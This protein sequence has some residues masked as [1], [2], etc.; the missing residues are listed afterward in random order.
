MPEN[1]LQGAAP[2]TLFPLKLEIGYDLKRRT[3][4]V[5]WYPDACQ[6][7]AKPHADSDTMLRHYL[8]EGDY[9]PALP[10]TVL[11][12]TVDAVGAVQLLAEA[13]PV[14][15]ELVKFA[16]PN[17]DP[18]FA[19][20]QW[21]WDFEVA[22]QQG[23]GITLS[24]A[25]FDRLA[26]A[27]WL[28]A[29]GY[30]PDDNREVVGILLSHKG[31]D[32]LRVLADGEPTNNTEDER[33]S[34][35]T[36]APSPR[37]TEA[38]RPIAAGVETNS[39][40]LSDALDGTGEVWNGI[41]NSDLTDREIQK[42][43]HI[44][45]WDACT[46]HL[47]D[48]GKLSKERYD[49]LRSAFVD[50]VR[51]RGYLPGL[52]IGR[53]P[54]GLLVAM[55]NERFGDEGLLSMLA[56]PPNGPNNLRSKLLGLALLHGRTI[57]RNARGLDTL[58]A[59]FK[60]AGAT[61][62]LAQFIAERGDI[63]YDPAES[64][65]DRLLATLR[66][67][68]V[69]SRCD[70]L[71]TDG[72]ATQHEQ[73]NV[74]LGPSDYLELP[75]DKAGLDMQKLPLF[76]RLLVLS[77][78]AAEA[79]GRK[80]QFDDSVKL[81]FST[82]KG[83]L[84][85]LTTLM[86]EAL[87]CLSYRVDAWV[88][89]EAVRRLKSLPAVG[90]GRTPGGI[91]VFGWLENPVSASSQVPCEYHQAPSLAQAQTLAV[92]R[93]GSLT[94]E[95]ALHIDLSG[96]RTSQAL[97]LMGEMLAGIPLAEALG[98]EAAAGFHEA[99]ADGLLLKLRFLRPFNA[100]TSAVSCPIDGETFALCNFQEPEK[101]SE[102]FK[103]IVAAVKAAVSESEYAT[104]L[105]IWRD[106][107][108]QRDALADLS[109]AEAV[110]EYN[111]GNPARAKS[112][113]DVAEGKQ[114]PALP[115]VVRSPVRCRNVQQRALL[116]T[117][118][119]TAAG[120][121]E[122]DGLRGVV[123]PSFALLCESYL[124][125]VLEP[126]KPLHCLVRRLSP[127]TVTRASPAVPVD[128]YTRG[129]T[130]PGALDLPVGVMDVVLGGKQEV[131]RR[132]KVRVLQNMAGTAT[133]PALRTLST[134]T[135]A[136]MAKEI[137]IE[138]A[139]ERWERAC[140]LGARLAALLKNAQ[141]LRTIDFSLEYSDLV[142]SADKPEG[143]VIAA[144]REAISQLRS[145]APRA[146][147]AGRYLEAL[148]QR[149]RKVQDA[150]AN[151]GADV[152]AQYLDLADDIVRL[153]LGDVLDLGGLDAAAAAPGGAKARRLGEIGEQ[154]DKRAAALLPFSGTKFS[155][156]LDKSI[157]VELDLEEGRRTRFVVSTAGVQGQDELALG[158]PDAT[159]KLRRSRQETIVDLNRAL[160]DGV[161]A[162]AVSAAVDA[163]AIAAQTVRVELCRALAGSCGTDWDF[164]LPPVDSSSLNKRWLIDGAADPAR[165]L[166][167]LRP[168]LEL[169]GRL[170]QGQPGA[171]KCVVCTDRTKEEVEADIK[172]MLLAAE[173]T[174]QEVKSATIEIV[175]DAPHGN[176][177][178]HLYAASSSSF[179]K[180]G[181]A[182]TITGLKIDEWVDA[183]NVEAQ[184]TAIAFNFDVPQAEAPNAILIT[185][186]S[187]AAWQPGEV[188][189]SLSSVLD[190]LR[191]RTLSID[192]LLTDPQIAA[193]LP[194]PQLPSDSPAFRGLGLMVAKAHGPLLKAE[195]THLVPGV[196]STSVVFV[197]K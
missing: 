105:R 98:Q 176:T 74:N 184:D 146:T 79:A 99:K 190:L 158:E 96:P 20:S 50:D 85:E 128:V 89:A 92:L 143:H 18:T 26:A 163:A 1:L 69:S 63:A 23:M 47:L 40:L 70:V 124:K 162:A 179:E 48:E 120:R 139:D 156:R 7:K 32:R 126:S 17:R 83:R 53:N 101:N 44:C 100:A 51:G 67:D 157:S 171:Y 109:V 197:R 77:E 187:G 188:A 122:L 147:E 137:S 145:L 168:N 64:D 141:E 58:A 8:S 102:D 56:D 175:E 119:V 36:A 131:E 166:E 104:I 57:H 108:D 165:T 14:K 115:E 183:I 11:L 125:T 185:V 148:Q 152:D 130:A 46:R 43:V 172:K 24:G 135:S 61:G 28:L 10:D 6:V 31:Q 42:Q 116:L 195:Q 181:T 136:E 3:A 95:S 55:A 27:K 87:D 62:S 4:D 22:K 38:A 59:A 29:V 191:L 167:L 117:D 25:A 121:P 65:L 15:H 60:H 21:L 86:M 178:L 9:F 149:V 110:H 138:I 151:G 41:P 196:P 103:G 192:E 106:V 182:G 153:N 49:Q 76:T 81:L 30:R 133:L 13:S 169:W 73:A 154:I 132:L 39:K 161:D 2:I 114:V 144:A 35:L 94:T 177:D 113:L 12:H 160:P 155:V 107:Q 71:T 5:R 123:E 159:L 33:T 34:G 54:Y 84:P 66:Q 189:R 193:V 78:G 186:P 112:W 194:T 142:P 97:K 91:G 174:A 45:L 150:I 170:E 127:G 72:N 82:Y 75:A 90:A 88:T 140:E 134:P 19:T 164:V 68:A 80:S 180:L 93:A 16:L 52:R 173:K 129:S 111:L 118:Y 37:A